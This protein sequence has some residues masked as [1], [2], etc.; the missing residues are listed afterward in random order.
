MAIISNPQ[1][2]DLKDIQGMVTRGYGK[3]YKTA[4]LFLMVTD[5]ER[6]QNWLK[7][8][9]L[10]QIN[11]AAPPNRVLADG[12]TPVKL[13]QTLHLALTANGLKALGLSEVN[14]A[15]FPIPFRQGMVQDHRSRQLG[16]YGDNDP[17]N[18]YWGKTIQEK[19]L[20]LLLIVHAVDDSTRQ[21]MIDTVKEQIRNNQA[22]VELLREY[23]GHQRKDNREPFG[24]HDGISQPVI[25][26]SGRGGPE[27]DM[28]ETG[29]FLLGYKNEYNEYPF[30]PLITEQQG[31][32]ELLP[33]DP[34][35]SNFKDLGK[36]G[37]F[38][39]YRQ[40][41]QHT[42][43]FWAYM[44]KNAPTQ[45]ENGVPTEEEAIAFAAKC[46]GRWPSGASLVNF[47]DKDPKPQSFPLPPLEDNPDT[48]PFD[49]DDFGYA[50]KD[51]YGQRCPF[52][53]HLRRN[54]PRDKFRWYGPKQSLKISRRHRIIR[55][56]RNY[57]IVPDPQKPDTK[58]IG[59]HFICFNSNIELQFEFIQHAW[60]NNNQLRD[61]NNDV[62]VIIGVP[63]EKDPNSSSEVHGNKMTIQAAP[64]NIFRSEKE[65]F[66]TIKGGEYFFFP[67]LTAIEYLTTL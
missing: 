10:P 15:N 43:T 4:Y 22:G 66:V 59:L 16:D 54:N 7:T 17:K 67:S 35:G 11:S 52:G 21:Q 5:R 56:G 9:I 45:S 2:L 60:A 13:T 38:M 64:T 1:T 44:K 18:W 48:D 47:P 61:M 29:E 32:T 30:S 24:F 28:V 39:V 25:K 55:R 42:D 37:T 63:N 46:V 33:E 12:K 53:S 41:Q 8:S 14:L 20:H 50:E 40:I 62:D 31:T 49:N 3:L 58:E 51:P 57:E 19:P 36:N 26:G 6:A 34:Q 27:N 65:R 23:E